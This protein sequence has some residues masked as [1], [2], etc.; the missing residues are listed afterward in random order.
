MDAGENYPRVIYSLNQ[1]RR[2]I[3]A[4]SSTTMSS[5]SQG[6]FVASISAIACTM[7]LCSLY[8]HMRIDSLGSTERR[9]CDQQT[10]VW[11]HCFRDRGPF[12]PIILLRRLMT[13]CALT[14]YQ[15]L[16]RT[17]LNNGYRTCGHQT[18]NPSP[19]PVPTPTAAWLCHS[20]KTLHTVTQLASAQEK[21]WQGLDRI[22]KK[23]RYDIGMMDQLM[24]RTVVE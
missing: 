9:Q 14:F 12:R 10:P 13:V 22:T 8:A 11:R 15:E 4:P 19:Q 16:R 20:I 7:V 24:I 1:I 17:L 23:H 18:P 2:C 21:T 3:G 5:I 6:Y